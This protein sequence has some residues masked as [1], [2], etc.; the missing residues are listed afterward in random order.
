VFHPQGPHP[1]PQLHEHIHLL[2]SEKTGY[3]FSPFQYEAMPYLKDEVIFQFEAR[4]TKMIPPTPQRDEAEPHK[5]IFHYSRLIQ[6]HSIIAPNPK[7]LALSHNRMSLIWF[8][9]THRQFRVL[10]TQSGVSRRRAPLTQTP[11]S[12]RLSSIFLRINDLFHR[13]F[14]V[15]KNGDPCQNWIRFASCC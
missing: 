15:A 11:P 7:G 6:N 2:V 5:I 13:C 9:I 12:L 10:L 4:T 14:R 3:T 1:P 8:R